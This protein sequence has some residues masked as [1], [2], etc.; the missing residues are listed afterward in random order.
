MVEPVQNVAGSTHAAGETPTLSRS[1]HRRVIVASVSGTVI[2]W[3]DFTLYAVASALIFGPQFFPGA[4][5]V[6]A[7]LA[8][9]GT[10]AIG[11]AVRPIG[12]FVFAHFG[13]RIGRKPIMLATVLTMGLSTTVIGL[14]P[15]AAVAGPAAAWLLIVLR[16]MQGLAVGAEF[17]GA[18]TLLNETSPSE[19]RSFTSGFAS[20]AS[21]IGN[22]IATVGFA[23]LALLPSNVFESW[24][25]RIPF[26]AT[27]VVVAVAVYVRTRIEETPAFRHAAQANSI[28]RLP[29][30]AV[31]RERPRETVCVALVYCLAM[32]WAY[33][34]QT[35]GL[36]Y[37]TRTL[38]LSYLTAT[39]CLVVAYVTL[40]P[41]LV[42]FGSVADRISPKR[43]LIFSAIGSMVWAYPMFAAIDSKQPVLV[44]G[45]IV[46]GLLISQGVPSAASTVMVTNAFRTEYRWTGI[47]LSREVAAAV[48]GGT[49]PL[50]AVGLLTLG[51]GQPWWICGFLA[52]AAALSLVGVFAMPKHVFRHGPDVKLVD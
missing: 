1:Q 41:A 16:V 47:I 4:G 48:I 30:V 25:W 51:G 5:P 6:G 39:V 37:M 42:L 23:L 38:H 8:S 31:L 33:T 32:P 11:V 9:F 2:E 22:T 26:L 3:Y 19:H 24:A 15:T 43:M 20:S 7:V 10:F 45:A 34:V 49:A 21:Y 28:P 52:A 50:I 13:D 12:G 27:I 14:L 35:F 36:N 46:I 29:I 44:G 40:I 18:I 17:A